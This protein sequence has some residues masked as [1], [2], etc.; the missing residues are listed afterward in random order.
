MTINNYFQYTDTVFSHATYFRY[1]RRFFANKLYPKRT[2][3]DTYYLGTLNFLPF[4][5]GVAGKNRDGADELYLNFLG[6]FTNSSSTQVAQ[7]I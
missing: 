7:N 5:K 1:S 6:L 4:F 3:H 2:V